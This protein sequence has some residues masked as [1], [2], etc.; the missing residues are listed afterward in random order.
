MNDQEMCALLVLSYDD[1]DDD[2][3]YYV[4]DDD[5]DDDDDYYYYCSAC[6]ILR[7]PLSFLKIPLSFGSR[8]V[9]YSIACFASTGSEPLALAGR[10]FSIDWRNHPRQSEFVVVEEK[11]LVSVSLFA[12]SS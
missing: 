4:Y 8:S 10:Y 7:T 11:D 2:G 1:D 5:D 12:A 3:F 6:L 9:V